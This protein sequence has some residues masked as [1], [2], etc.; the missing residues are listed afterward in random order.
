MKIKQTEQKTCTGLP[1]A[2]F[3]KSIQKWSAAKALKVKIRKFNRIPSDS[4][5]V[6]GNWYDLS[7]SLPSS[8]EVENFVD[9]LNKECEATARVD[10]HPDSPPTAPLIGETLQ[11]LVVPAEE[12]QAGSPRPL[13]ILRTPPRSPFEDGMTEDLPLPDLPSETPPDVEATVSPPTD[14]NQ[15]EHSQQEHTREEKEDSVPQDRT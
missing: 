1:R 11:L 15:E 5:E 8:P 13:P 3:P 4:E 12:P 2:K 14:L 9:H 10:T 6:P 7:P